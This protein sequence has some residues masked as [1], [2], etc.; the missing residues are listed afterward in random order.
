ML[1]A[2]LEHPPETVLAL[3]DVETVVLL[4][5]GLIEDRTSTIDDA[6]ERRRSG[7]SLHDD[8]ETLCD[9]L[10]EQFGQDKSDDIALLVLRLTGRQPRP[11]A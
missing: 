8:P 2:R 7:P 10:L 5:A 9:D 4:T 1:G 3:D 6:I 11:P